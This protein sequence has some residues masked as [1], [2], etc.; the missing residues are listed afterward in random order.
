MEHRALEA[1]ERQHIEHVGRLGEHFDDRAPHI[2]LG[3]GLGIFAMVIRLEAICQA[4]M[5]RGRWSVSRNTRAVP[6]KLIAFHSSSVTFV[7]CRNRGAVARRCR[8][9]VMSEISFSTVCTISAVTIMPLSGAV[10]LGVEE[11]VDRGDARGP[12]APSLAISALRALVSICCVATSRAAIRPMPFSNA[13][14]LS[15][16]SFA[17]VRACANSGSAS[18]SLNSTPSGGLKSFGSAS[19]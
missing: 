11:G 6:R 4:P 17:H 9:P 14:W 2:L 19:L 10:A 7:G 15:P 3:E 5:R 13:S 16:F 18:S 8:P 12:L 1:L